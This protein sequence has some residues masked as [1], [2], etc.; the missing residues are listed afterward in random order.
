[1]ITLNKIYRVLLVSFV[2]AAIPCISF[3]ATS[4]TK[5]IEDGAKY[6]TAV[7]ED[8]LASISSA[9]SFNTAVSQVNTDLTAVFLA[10]WASRLNNTINVAIPNN[11]IIEEKAIDY[12]CIEGSPILSSSKT[13][14]GDKLRYQP[15]TISEFGIANYLNIKSSVCVEST[16]IDLEDHYEIGYINWEDTYLKKECY[17]KG[18]EDYFETR[19]EFT[20]CAQYEDSSKWNCLTVDV[21]NNDGTTEEK[22]N[23]GAINDLVSYEFFYPNDDDAKVSTCG[24]DFTKI[25]TIDTGI[26]SIID[27]CVTHYKVL[28]P[29]IYDLIT[30]TAAPPSDG[31]G[32]SGGG[33]GD[34]D[35]P[36][37]EVG[38]GDDEIAEVEAAF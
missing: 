37:P 4:S 1:M 31:G 13:T 30:Y 2:V 18:T 17:L 20:P 11:A 9:T 3:G 21:V 25:G 16:E 29:Q 28:D 32:S 19:F 27:L 24:M 35:I 15:L 34:G 23:C 5:T 6:S 14:I 38:L 36:P 10:D 12:E 26:K 7:S 33:L 8:S 22:T